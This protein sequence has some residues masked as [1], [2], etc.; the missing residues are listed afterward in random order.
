M[1]IFEQSNWIIAKSLSLKGLIT[2]SIFTNFP[3]EIKTSISS[4]LLP[5]ITWLAVKILHRL[6]FLP[7]INPVPLDELLNIALTV[8]SKLRASTSSLILSISKEITSFPVN[9][10]I[11]K[12]SN[13]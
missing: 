4:N 3:G 6:F 2:L 1:S 8:L 5:S 9:K 12:D 11:N 7:I 10:R 13:L